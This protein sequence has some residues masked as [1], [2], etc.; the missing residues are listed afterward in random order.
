MLFPERRKAYAGNTTRNRPMRL[1]KASRPIDTPLQPWTLRATHRHP[2]VMWL[3]VSL[4]VLQLLLGGIVFMQVQRHLN[5]G[6]R[7]ERLEKKQSLGSE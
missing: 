4:I 6:E 2:A 3:I 1:R 5:L 7:I